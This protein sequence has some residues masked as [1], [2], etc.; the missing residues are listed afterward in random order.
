LF[1]LVVAERWVDGDEIAVPFALIPSLS[2]DRA[3]AV[4]AGDAECPLSESTEKLILKDSHKIY[5]SLYRDE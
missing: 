1:G 4:L 5:H 3:V 2:P